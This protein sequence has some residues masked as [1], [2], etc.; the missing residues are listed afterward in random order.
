M[1]VEGIHMMGAAQCPEEIICDTTFTTSVPCSLWHWCLTPWLLWTRD[2]FAVLGR[3]SPPWRGHLGLDFV[4]DSLYV[5]AVFFYYLPLSYALVNVQISL[6]QKDVWGSDSGEHPNPMKFIQEKV[7]WH[8]K[9]KRNVKANLGVQIS[10]KSIHFN[11]IEDIYKNGSACRWQWR[12][13]ITEANDLALVADPE[14][15][16]MHRMVHLCFIG[17]KVYFSVLPSFLLIKSELQSWKY[18]ITTNS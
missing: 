3:Y 4:A 17:I 10:W 11:F 5:Y 9:K 6:L 2:L 1:L 7:P 16:W 15:L 13:F 14:L 12:H 18:P 8:E